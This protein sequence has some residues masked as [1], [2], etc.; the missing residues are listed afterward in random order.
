MAVAVELS[1][2]EF[3]VRVGKKRKFRI[4]MGLHS[5]HIGERSYGDSASFDNEGIIGNQY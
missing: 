2:P 3:G 1:A 4:E 5:Y